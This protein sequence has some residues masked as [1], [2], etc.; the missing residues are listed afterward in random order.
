MPGDDEPETAFYVARDPASGEVVSTGSVRHEVPP[1]DPAAQQADGHL[2]AGGPW[3]VPVAARLAADADSGA[4]GPWRL[5]G[6][7][8]EEH[9][10]GQGVGRRVLDAV[11]SHVSGAGG[12]LLWCSARI[13]AVPFYE[14]AGF[15]TIGRVFDE[16]DIGPHML[17]WRVVE[18]EAP[19]AQAAA[20]STG[21]GA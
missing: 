9:L 19:S 20:P 16:P 17:M 14:R 21:A 18:A 12:G 6:M 11:V 8:T 10:R 15:A 7:A 13:R 4:A 1:W 5:R 3:D 2:A